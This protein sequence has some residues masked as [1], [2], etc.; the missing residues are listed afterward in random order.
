MAYLPST[1]SWKGLASLRRKGQRPMG[2]VYLSPDGGYRFRQWQNRGLYCLPPD[3][4]V[5]LLSG[6]SVLMMAVKT[7][8]LVE[9]AQAVLSVNPYRFQIQW[10]GEPWQD[11]I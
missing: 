2:P 4:E 6:L 3:G 5:V 10:K 11:V 9:Y 1:P 7:S 8:Q